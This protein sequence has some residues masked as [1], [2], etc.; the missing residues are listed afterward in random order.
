MAP[1]NNAWM[2]SGK[3]FE[4]AIPERATPSAISA[5]AAPKR[6]VGMEATER[7]SLHTFHSLHPQSVLGGAII[8]QI[9]VF[10][11]KAISSLR[12]IRQRDREPQIAMTRKRETP[13]TRSI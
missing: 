12:R 11:C 7:T 10:L 4:L 6:S 5:K 13:H 2:P 8:G 9:P 3:A 1:P